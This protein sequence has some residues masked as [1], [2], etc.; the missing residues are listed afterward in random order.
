MKSD[1]W[2]T[3]IAINK[4]LDITKT[5]T[6]DTY[7]GIDFRD[8]NNVRC[9]WFGLRQRKNGVNE[10]Q[11]QK[12]KS[13]F[14][15][16]LVDCN[17]PSNSSGNEML[18]AKWFKTSTSQIRTVIDAGY[19]ANTGGF[20]RVWNDGWK[21]QGGTC[22][23][24]QDSNTLVTL[25]KAYNNTLYTVMISPETSSLTVGSQ[26]VESVINKTTTSFGWANGNDYAGNGRWYAC[27]F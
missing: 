16:F 10:I 9:A 14:T 5:P 15:N 11:I 12:Q 19:D 26:G 8:V 22:A 13:N 24:K 6:N 4:N 20:Y 7:V 21:E 17:P 1:D 2:Q 3:F 23:I 25:Y 27:G 18:P